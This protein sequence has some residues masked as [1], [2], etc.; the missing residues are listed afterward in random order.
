MAELSM[1]AEHGGGT[2]Y[3]ANGF[4]VPV[5]RGSDREMG[6]QYGALMVDRM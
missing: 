6:A 4:V 2:L 5:L 1:V 3:E